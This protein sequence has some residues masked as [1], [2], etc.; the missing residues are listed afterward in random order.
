MKKR[1]IVSVLAVLAT[2]FSF[3]LADMDQVTF[4]ITVEQNTPDWANVQFPG[5]TTLAYGS[6]CVYYAQVW[7]NGK[8]GGESKFEDIEA[9]IGYNTVDLAPS[10]NGW[11]W[12]PATYNAQAIDVGNNDEYFAEIAEGLEPGTYYVASRFSF[13]GDMANVTYGLLGDT[14]NAVLTIQ[15]IN[16]APVFAAI[17]DQAMDEDTGLSLTLEASDVDNDELTF[18]V[19][20]NDHPNSVFL[21]I[22]GQTLTI[23]LLQ[24]FFTLE[25]A[26]ISLKVS[27]GQGGEDIVS[28]K[29]T[30]NPVNDAPVIAAME[31][32]TATE[33][34]EI[35]I[36]FSA[37]DVD[38]EGSELNWNQSGAPSGS[39]FTDN[40][41]G[42]AKLVWTPDYTQAGVYENI[43]ITVDDGTAQTQSLVIKKNKSS[44]R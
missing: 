36:N 1:I 7:E 23:T 33:G 19:E 40:R 16:S 12:I 35:I 15:K 4:S 32:Q 11:T 29:L 31:S 43:V 14:A 25:P 44:N 26:N 6:S 24:D 21:E 3:V 17:G 28:F 27:D 34:N 2:M 8:T 13:I 37:T 30:V 20:S 42:T 41:D 38:N 39:V 5:D 22:T 9:W 10:E 18:S